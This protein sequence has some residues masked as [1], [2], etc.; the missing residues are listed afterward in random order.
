MTV[1]VTYGSYSFP[2]DSLPVITLDRTQEF[3][4][5]GQVSKQTRVINLEGHVV[6][7]TEDVWDKWDDLEAAFVKDGKDFIFK[8]LGTTR[9][10]ILAANSIAGPR[11]TS[12]PGIP[13]GTRAMGVSQIPYS[14]TIESIETLVQDEEDEDGPSGG[15]DGAVKLEQT[16]R[17]DFDKFNLQTRT[18]SGTLEVRDGVSAL[19][20]FAELDPGV[21]DGWQRESK[22]S[23]T[24]RADL[25]LQYEYVDK[26]LPI[27]NPQDIKDASR[28]ESVTIE[29]GVRRVRIS[30]S[31]TADKRNFQTAKLRAEAERPVGRNLTRDE[32]SFDKHRGSA[33]FSFEYLEQA[34]SGIFTSHDETV[35]FR[36]TNHFAFMKVKS[37]GKPD[38]RQV[39]SNPTYEASVSGERRSLRT[40]PRPPRH[41]YSANDLIDEDVQRSYERSADGR[42]IVEFI[43]TWSRSYRFRSKR[44]IRSPNPP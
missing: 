31:Y 10:S 24:N 36:V 42:R 34:R 3:D 32:I 13:D 40:Y 18:I 30:G 1:S 14:I 16:T 2:L 17:F 27:A 15:I 29:N 39:A 26:E 33:N 20:K 11:I 44:S 22:S 38:Y 43:T 25:E 7:E 28:V 6:G 21:P 37:A 12:G 5:N 8:T 35:S 4:E 19:S 41:V 9:I 23:E